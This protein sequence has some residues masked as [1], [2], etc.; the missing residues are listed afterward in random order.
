MSNKERITKDRL[1]SYVSLKLEIENR[2]ERLQRL[3]NEAEMPAAKLD[4]ESKHTQGAGDRMERAIIRYM[5]YEDK[6]RPYLAQAD[7]ELKYIDDAIDSI[8]DPLEREV[9]RLRYTDGE[10]GRLMPWKEVSLKIFGDDDDKHIL[11]TYRLHGKAIQ[12]ICR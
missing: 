11:A 2:L 7:A 9:L 10:Y 12:D 6:I 4:D 5:E 8:N 1:C 3:K